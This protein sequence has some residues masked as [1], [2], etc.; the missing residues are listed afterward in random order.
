MALTGRPVDP[1]SQAPN[2]IE[3]ADPSALVPRLAYSRLPERTLSALIEASATINATLELSVVLDAIARSAA[4]VLRAEASSVLMLDRR[5]NK[6]VFLA[7]C[8]DRADTLIGAEFDANL[9][10][11][12]H[13]AA[14]GAPTLV[15]D[16][17]QDRYFFRGIDDKS[18][19]H[20]RGLVASPL[21]Y[22]GEI[23]GVVE[24]L[25]K[26]AGVFEREDLDLLQIFANLAASAAHN[27]QEH[28]TVV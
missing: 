11:A 6:L 5:R 19:F 23:I 20:T 3:Q 28:D 10:I 24:V 26:M 15:A 17:S 22:R 16:V 18:S 21:V 7:A 2:S 1:A 9:G 25:N 4:M 14:T 13:V 27:A 8:G 12:G